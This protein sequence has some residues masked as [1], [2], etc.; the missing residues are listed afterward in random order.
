LFDILCALVIVLYVGCGAQALCKHGH[1]AQIM[2]RCQSEEEAIVDF[3]EMVQI[4]E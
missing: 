1:K 3:K 2:D 4:A